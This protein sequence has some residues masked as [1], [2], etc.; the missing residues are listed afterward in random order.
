MKTISLS[1]LFILFCSPLVAAPLSEA[2]QKEA[3]RLFVAL[4]CQGCHDFNRSGSNL[5]ESL[6]RIGL[7]LNEAQ[8]LERLQRPPER[9]GKGDK[10]MPS[11]QTSPITQL[12]LLSRFLAERK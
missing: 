12:K 2:D 4:G 9:H 7:K 5:A 8:I 3:W 1:I 10:F 6:D 11:Y